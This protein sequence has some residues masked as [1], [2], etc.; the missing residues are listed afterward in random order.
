MRYLGA[1]AASHTDKMTSQWATHTHHASVVCIAGR[2]HGLTVAN[3][4]YDNDGNPD[5]D[6]TR[7]SLVYQN[8]FVTLTA[9]GESCTVCGGTDAQK[10]DYIKRKM[11][12]NSYLWDIGAFHKLM[13]AVQIGGKGDEHTYAAY[14]EIRKAGGIIATAHEHSYERTWILNSFSGCSPYTDTTSSCTVIDNTDPLTIWN[15]A[16]GRTGQ[17]FAFVSG[18][19]GAGNRNQQRCTGST[20]NIYGYPYGCNGEWASAMTTDDP[21][22]DYGAFF[23]EFNVDGDAR[24]ARAYFKTAK[25]CS[26]NTSKWN[27]GQIWENEPFVIIND[28]Q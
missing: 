18:A 17:S 16:G 23:I 21:T 7:S 20:S 3:G 2:R 10:A 5:N 27:C 14:D 26:T 22:Q 24:K 11:N 25:Q 9:P 6:G 8:L 12:N 4:K 28:A 13:R 15:E 19:G 1:I